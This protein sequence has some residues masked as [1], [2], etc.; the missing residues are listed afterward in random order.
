MKSKK[1]IWVVDDDQ[2]IR[3]VVEKALSG[4][5]RQIRCFE[6]GDQALKALEVS[7][8]D[9]VITD[10]RM[11][12]ASGQ[13]LLETFSEKAPTVPVVVMTAYSDLDTTVGAFAGGAYEYLPKP[14]DLDEMSAVVERALQANAQP[15]S[16]AI[17]AGPEQI[18]IGESPVMQ[19]LFRHIGRLSRSELS[20]LITGETGTGKE[21]IAR[22]LH[23]HS[24]RSKEPF[25]GLNTAA[26]PRDLLESELFG[27]ERG[28]FTGAT[29]RHHGRFEQAQGGTL[30][31]DEIGDMPGNLQT[32]LLRV[33]AEGEFYR[34]GGREL[35]TVDVRVIAATHQDL[36]AKVKS[37]TFREDLYHRLNVVELIA[38]PLRE[39]GADVQ[40]LADRFL[41]EAAAEMQV[42][43]KQLAGDARRELPGQDWPGNVRELRNL[44][45]RLTVM[46]AGPTI[47]VSDIVDG[48]VSEAHQG[49]AENWEA[50]FL[51]WL[52]G[53]FE[54]NTERLLAGAQDR[55]QALMLRAA[56]NRTG[57]R[58][59]EAAKLLGCGRNTLTRRLRE[60]GLE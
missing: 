4:S 59:Q 50:G 7:H 43:L 47:H 54:A 56:L 30:F 25:I 27:H 1:T 38:P 31:L 5:D 8:P 53:Q 9:L 23:E 58:R 52:D 33:L 12:H 37:K 49:S 51:A 40:L 36:R 48:R 17:E 39:R 28:A 60:L 10:L 14:F 15:S 6:D 42:D 24:P 35:I 57:G 29:Q 11:P 55:L 2:S 26:I 41:N 18:L 44:C 32:R 16:G 3:W 20:V 13:V 21:L 19:Q 34:V 22:A 45:R 46:T